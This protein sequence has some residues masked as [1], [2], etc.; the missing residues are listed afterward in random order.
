MKNEHN[1]RFRD[2]PSFDAKD[3]HSTPLEP[4]EKLGLKLSWVTFRN[5]LNE[6]EQANIAQGLVWAMR[7]YSRRKILN[8]IFV[9][10]LHR[11][12]LGDVWEWAGKFRSTERN[13]GIEAWRIA[14]E[15]RT[16]VDDASAWIEYGTYEADELA[17][18]FHHKLVSI[19]PFPNGN[20]RHSR[21]MAD[22]IVMK[23]DRPRFTWGG[24]SLTSAGQD[25]NLYISALRKADSGDIAELVAFARS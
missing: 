20:G 16:L 5:E 17:I 12:M 21:L 9:R 24:K 1:G 10:E 3:E 15:V 18:R 7:S 6:V 22:L 11:R 4:E 14:P 13:L 25:R 8:D 2:E 23:L 19:H